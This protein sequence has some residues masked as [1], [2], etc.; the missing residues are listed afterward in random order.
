MREESFSAL[1]CL[2]IRAETKYNDRD[3][4]DTSLGIHDLQYKQLKIEQAA[5][6]AVFEEFDFSIK[7]AHY[8]ECPLFLARLAKEFICKE[9]SENFE[10][11]LWALKWIFNYLNSEFSIDALRNQI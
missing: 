7:S 4:N 5:K 10:R 2:A 9:P 1:R 8:V 11:E 3:E 6:H